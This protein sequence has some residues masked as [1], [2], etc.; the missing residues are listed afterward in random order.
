M[1]VKQSIKV[2]NAGLSP[3][4]SVAQGTGAIEYEFTV[5]D[6]DI[7]S[8]SAVVAYNIQ[9]TGNIVSQTCSI[10]GN[11]ITVKPP[12]YYFLRGKNYMQ[13]QV[14]RS[15]E[16]LFSF[17]IEVWCAPNI[18]Q[19]EVI[20]AENPSL[21]SQLISD[22]GLL[23]SQLDN[24]LSIPSGSLSTSA[25]AALADIKVGWDGTTYDTPGDAVRG[26]IGELKGDLD[27]KTSYI[28]L[29]YNTKKLNLDFTAGYLSG[30]NGTYADLPLRGIVTKDS[31]SIDYTMRII[32]D[33][34]VCN[35]FRLYSYDENDNFLRVL[36][37]SSNQTD[38]FVTD[39]TK[40][41]KLFFY[42]VG[43]NGGNADSTQ[44]IINKLWHSFIVLD[45]GKRIND[46]I[47]IC[48]N[49]IAI[50]NK[51][52]KR[53]LIVDAN[54]NGE[55]TKI[56]DAVNVA[57]ED[58]IIY[59]CAGNYEETV[60]PPNGKHLNFVGEDKHKTVLFNTT[61]NYD[62]PP[63]WLT[64]GTVKNLTIYAKRDPKIDYSSIVKFAYG[65]HLDTAFR[66]S[67]EN[68]RCEISN[69]IIKSDFNDAIGSG[70]IT[71]SFYD[72]HDCFIVTT[73][74]GK[75]AFRC[76]LGLNQGNANIVLKNNVLVAPSNG[77]GIEFHNGNNTEQGNI[78]VLMVCN[79]AKRYHNGVPSVFIENDYCYGN[80]VANM[81]K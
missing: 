71:D 6:F 27:T 69:C 72:I 59:I 54:G 39:T 30:S 77:Y 80:D 7:P 64:N 4:L 36:D 40:K 5:S 11:T 62:T 74:S 42:P 44:E 79:V 75:S 48:V 61:G 70:V 38:V 34:S 31:F 29:K 81:N 57:N 45:H 76:H 56:M 52:T 19:P 2:T 63:I 21:V 10:S 60:I 65:F 68:K 25:D 15:N 9:P 28:E 18:S 66:S 20:V 37:Y 26:Q 33:N 23:S 47:K 1:S 58:D 17:L 32:I 12:A 67:A 14:S 43:N 22:V 3:I 49:A 16:D 35:G 13:F 46:D 41:Y 73:E 53:I 51:K 50:L 55:Y 8:G 78:D 24:L